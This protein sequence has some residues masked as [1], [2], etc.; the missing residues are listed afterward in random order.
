MEFKDRLPLTKEER[1]YP[2]AEYYDREPPKIGI[3]EKQLLEHANPID[4]KFAIPAEEWLS[5]LDNIE[6]YAEAEYG[7]CMLDEKRGYMANYL[8]FKTMP[9]EMTH[10]WY[11]WIN[12][13]PKGVPEDAG[14]LHYKIWYPGEHIDHGYI[15]GVDRSDGYFALDYDVEGNVV[16][17]RRYKVDIAEHGVSQERIDFLAKNNYFVD[18][19]W[20]TGEGGMRLSLNVTHKLPNGDTEKRTRTWIGYGLKDGKV[21]RDENAC[22]TEKMLKTTLTHQT[23]E[24]H[25][26]E[27]LV[28]ELYSRFGDKPAD[29]V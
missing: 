6:N 2:T 5:L 8:Y 14:S 29:S 25:Y 17:T 24:G 3:L 26:M 4:P 27:T 15:N 18:C 16:E 28:P 13:R 10:W 21:V 1:E 19:A 20:E 12:I 22:C 7:Y 23:I 9:A 11:G